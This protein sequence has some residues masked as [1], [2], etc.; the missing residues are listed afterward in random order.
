[1]GIEA[2]AVRKTLRP[3]LAEFLEH[4]VICITSGG[5]TVPLEQNMVRFIDN[6]SRGE[7]G[8]ASAESYLANGYKVIFL[9]RTGSIIPFTRGFRKTISSEIDF[10]LLASLE[11]KKQE[12]VLQLGNEG[13]RIKSELLC[14][15]QAKKQKLLISFEFETVTDYLEL[16]HVVAEELASLQEMAC[17]YLAAA[18]SDFYVPKEEVT[19]TNAEVDPF[20]P[21]S[22]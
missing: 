3:F 7:R 12:L 15:Q 20:G 10:D 14:Y 9:H 4:P 19:K 22:N 16:L 13:A 1:M 6:F 17:F 18:V 2:D 8:S 11:N 5:T 21:V